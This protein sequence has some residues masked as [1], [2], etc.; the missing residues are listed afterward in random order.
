MAA[1]QS[2]MADSVVNASRAIQFAYKGRSLLSYPNLEAHS[3]S[4]DA[5]GQQVCPNNTIATSTDRP[6]PVPSPISTAVSTSLS[7]CATKHNTSAVKPASMASPSTHNL[8]KQVAQL[9]RSNSP[10]HS[11]P[12]TWA[13]PATNTIASASKQAKSH[14]NF[15]EPSPSTVFHAAQSVAGC[16]PHVQS[17]SHNIDNWE[18]RLVGPEVQ[19]TSAVSSIPPFNFCSSTGPLY[20]P[21]F[22]SG[23]ATQ[24]IN[25]HVSFVCV[26]IS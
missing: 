4:L 21:F 5:N 13:T 2:L 16:L 9:C 1:S 7:E 17:R 26:H 23:S 3:P 8:D 18:Q 25:H 11:P 19:Q 12:T 6:L 20:S 15:Q 24:S 14:T 10:Q 22:T